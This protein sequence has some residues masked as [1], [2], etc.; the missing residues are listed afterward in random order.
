MVKLP[1][2]TTWPLPKERQPDSAARDRAFA[3][4]FLLASVVRLLSID[5]AEAYLRLKERAQ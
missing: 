1:V 3:K 4:A 2:N 5:G